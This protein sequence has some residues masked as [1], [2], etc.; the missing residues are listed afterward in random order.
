[1]TP[2]LPTEAPASWDAIIVGAGPAGSVAAIDL[3]RAGARVLI[4]DRA[5]FPRE[6]ACG[7]ALPPAAVDLLRELGVAVPLVFAERVTFV[8]PGGRAVSMPREA[9]I[10]GALVRRARLDSALLEAAMNRS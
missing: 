1:M 10:D 9:G 6:K 5:A 3:A 8:S 4:L 7:D 2:R